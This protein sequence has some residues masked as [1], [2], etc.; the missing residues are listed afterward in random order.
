MKYLLLE[1]I[2]I[3]HSEIIDVTAGTHGVLNNGVLQSIIERPKGQF[4]GVFLFPDIFSAA[5][6]YIESISRFH[7]FMDGNKRTAFACG[8]RFLYLQGYDVIVSNQEVVVVMLQVAQGQ[9]DVNQIA[10]WLRK[11]S[12]KINIVF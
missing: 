12:F 10:D 3:I 4:G 2:L 6:T 7:P 5:A 8:V 11:N 1:E 9:K